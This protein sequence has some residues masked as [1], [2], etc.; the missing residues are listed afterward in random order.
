MFRLFSNIL[1]AHMPNNDDLNISV[2]CNYQKVIVKEL[3]CSHIQNFPLLLLL[4]MK[5][6]RKE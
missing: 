6:A 2:C 4:N 1:L 5:S 3:H